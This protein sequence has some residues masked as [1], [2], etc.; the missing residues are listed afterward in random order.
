[1]RRSWSSASAGS[2]SISAIVHEP[3]SAPLPCWKRIYLRYQ[4]GPD[5]GEEH[6]A[7]G[8]A[9]GEGSIRREGLLS[10]SALINEDNVE[11]PKPPNIHERLRWLAKQK[12]LPLEPDYPGDGRFY[13]KG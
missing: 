9:T 2:T 11:I 10:R 13:R 3:S 6:G 7:P 4:P 1:V 12:V 8:Y 5:Q